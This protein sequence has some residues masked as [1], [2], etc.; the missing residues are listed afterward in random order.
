[1]WIILGHS[2]DE[3]VDE[4]EVHEAVEKEETPKTGLIIK[5]EEPAMV[6][7]KE[8]I[9]IIEVEVKTIHFKDAEDSVNGN[10]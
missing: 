3:D 10:D 7:H 1:M 9:S 5:I 8:S 6:S 4:I 2:E